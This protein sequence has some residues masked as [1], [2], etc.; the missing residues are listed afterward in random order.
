MALMWCV[1][2][3]QEEEDMWFSYLKC[4]LLSIFRHL[5]RPVQAII[6]F[7]LILPMG[8]F[9]PF[10][11]YGKA[12]SQEDKLIAGGPEA[13]EKILVL[14]AHSVVLPSPTFM[15]RSRSPL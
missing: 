2:A 13:E 10:F 1:F 9:L 5:A 6:S 4:L 12:D 14:R 3:G 15:K 8:T 7:V 11:T